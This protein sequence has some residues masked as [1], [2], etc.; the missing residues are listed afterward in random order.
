MKNSVLR[1]MI[2]CHRSA[3]RRK[4]LRSAGRRDFCAAR[5][6]CRRRGSC[7]SVR[8]RGRRAR[9]RA[10]A[11]ARLDRGVPARRGRWPQ[12]GGAAWRASLLRSAPDDRDRTHRRERR[13]HRPRWTFRIASRARADGQ[14]MARRHARVRACVRLAGPDAIAF[15]CAGFH[16]ERHPRRQNDARRMAESHARGY[17]GDAFADRGVESRADGAANSERQGA[18]REYRAWSRG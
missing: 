18:G 13:R 12:R 15:R 4:R 17:S 8:M 9:S 14:P 16:G 1:K 7:C 5:R 10:T 6:C 3:V 2:A 11:S